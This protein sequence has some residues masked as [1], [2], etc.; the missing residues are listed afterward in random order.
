MTRSKISTKYDLD[1]KQ[2]EAM[3]EFLKGK[4]SAETAGGDIGCSHQ[5]VIN[6]TTTLFRW[7]VFNKK[8]DIDKV[9]K[10]Y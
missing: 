8:I 5:Q 1:D 9:L 10:N 4:T 7:L 2:K 3:K 6:M